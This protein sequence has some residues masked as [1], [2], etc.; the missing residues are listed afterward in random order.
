MIDMPAS[1]PIVGRGNFRYQPRTAWEQLPDGWSF[2]EVAAVAVDSRGTVVVFNRGEHPVILL[3]PD[4][5]FQGAWGHGL[6]Q[7]AHGLCIAPDDTAYFIDDLDHTVKQFTLDGK[8]LLKLGT[9]G[10]PSGTG[11]TSMDYRSIRTAGAPFHYPTDLAIAPDG[12]LYVADGY[13]NSRVHR[14]S[15]DGRL[16]QSW[17]EPGSGPGQFKV[18][19]GIAVDAAG[20][21]FVADRENCRVQIFSGNGEYLAEWTNLARPCQ[22]FLDPTGN[23]Y[24]AELGWR[25]GM[26]PGTEPPTPDAPSGRLT[27]LAPDGSLLAR[28]GGGHD[29]MAPD[30][31][32]AP[33]DVIV[34]AAG[35]IYLGEVTWSGGVNRGLAPRE[36]PS[37]RTFAPVAGAR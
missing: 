30:A 11:A 27:I 6:F 37:L 15:P 17:G 14:F 16:I 13:G 7:R 8:P 2:V 12:D 19:H 1:P 36:C 24:I 10:S 32:F 3:N 31:F 35:V 20:R 33:H 23:A 18:P 26:W 29:P 25:A 22:V 5:S 4:G 28:W 9:S 34:H 21:V